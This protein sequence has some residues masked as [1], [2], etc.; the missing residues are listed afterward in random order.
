M[1]TMTLHQKK[2]GFYEQPLL[3]EI[4]Y[5]SILEFIKV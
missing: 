5:H 1:S 2:E 3:K 4:K